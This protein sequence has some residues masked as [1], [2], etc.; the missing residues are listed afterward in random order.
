MSSQLGVPVSVVSGDWVQTTLQPSFDAARTRQGAGGLIVIAVDSNREGNYVLDRIRVHARSRGEVCESVAVATADPYLMW[1]EISG[2]AERVCALCRFQ[3]GTVIIVENGFMMPARVLAER[4]A[5]LHSHARAHES[6]IVFPVAHPVVKTLAGCDC[7]EV[8]PFA[9]APERERRSLALA[10]LADAC[11]NE[12]VAWHERSARDLIQ[13]GPV[14]REELE[15]WVDYFAS[16][17][18][19][20]RGPWLVPP[21]ISRRPQGPAEVP[22]KDELRARFVTAM[23]RLRDADD[24]FVA[25]RG[26]PL[27]R[28]IRRPPDPFEAR[29]PVHWFMACVSYLA[30]F[31][32]DAVHASFTTLLDYRWNESARSVQAGPPTTFLSTLRALRTVMQHGLDDSHASTTETVARAEAW[33]VSSCGRNTPSAEQYRGLTWRLLAEW[34]E[35]TRNLEAVVANAAASETRK[36]VEVQL[37]LALRRLPKHRWRELLVDAAQRLSVAVDVDRVLQRKLGTL[38]ARLANASVENAAVVAEA[39]RAAGDAIAAE[40]ARCPVAAEDLLADGIVGGPQIGRALAAA[41]ELWR[42][43]PTLTRQQ[44][45][46]AVRPNGDLEGEPPKPEP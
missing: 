35:V 10:L 12:E 27:M 23:R 34:D 5:S 13:G 38:Q 32:F 9:L 15:G 14:S 44:L 36:L 29:D 45:L 16:R 26:E 19:F 21:P 7:I 24:A 30:C 6:H 11:P 46:D 17:E 39:R 1:D 4:V 40:C 43:D 22:S 25:W 8:P 18:P 20:D 28:P 37:D 33:F 2:S 3:P 31:A 41:T 42:K